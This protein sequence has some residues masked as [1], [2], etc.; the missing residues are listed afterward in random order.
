MI[1]ELSTTTYLFLLGDSIIGCLL[2]SI[3][4]YSSPK[5]GLLAGPGPA[6]SSRSSISNPSSLVYF[7]FYPKLPSSFSTL[8]SDA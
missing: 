4:S 2:A 5:N 1:A 7:L 6:S 3:V 8:L